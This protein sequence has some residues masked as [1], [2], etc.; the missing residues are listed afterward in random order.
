MVLDSFSHLS[1]K[2]SNEYGDYFTCSLFCPICNKE[3]KK[4]NIRDNIEGKWAVVIML[5][6]KLISQ[7]L[8]ELSKFNSNSNRKS[9][10]RKL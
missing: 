2:Y 6:Q 4:E 10:I 1:L 8:G 7:M 3:H 9:I 5:I